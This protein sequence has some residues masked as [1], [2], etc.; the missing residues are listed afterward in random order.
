MSKHRTG[1]SLIEAVLVLALIAVI[2]TAAALSLGGRLSSTRMEDA[3]GRLIEF[4]RVTREAGRSQPLGLRFDLNAGTLNRTNGAAYN[5]G[6]GY[7]VSRLWTDSGMSQSGEKKVAFSRRGQSPTYAT[8]I[9][10]ASSRQWVVF[11]GMTGKAVLIQDERELDELFGQQA[12][13]RRDAD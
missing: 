1:F 8:L 11:A 9:E 6:G 13:T 2:T 10:G 12:G 3:V 4:D 7:R 5:P